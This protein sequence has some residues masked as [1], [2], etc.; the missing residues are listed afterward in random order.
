MTQRNGIIWL[1]TQAIGQLFKGSAMKSTTAASRNRAAADAPRIDRLKK[2]PYRQG[3]LKV[4]DIRKAVNAVI[5]ER[6]TA[7]RAAK[8]AK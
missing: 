6:L 2:L 1:P 7:E 3:R 5:N 8:A 4:S